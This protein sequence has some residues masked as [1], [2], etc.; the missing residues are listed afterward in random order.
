M[1]SAWGSSWGVSWASAWGAAAGGGGIVGCFYQANFAQADFIQPCPTPPVPTPREV[2]WPVVGRGDRHRPTH[3]VGLAR[4]L[5]RQAA[6]LRRQIDARQAELRRAE[7]DEQARIARAKQLR[8]KKHAA[9]E[10]AAARR[11][12]ELQQAHIAS[13]R[14]ELAQLQLRRAELE[15]EQDERARCNA[16]CFLLLL[17]N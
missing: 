16:A 5:R 14:D 9:A 2:W 4:E 13:L 15:R 11:T 1:A 7:Q 6:E 8:R 12:E 10:L 3:D 17:A